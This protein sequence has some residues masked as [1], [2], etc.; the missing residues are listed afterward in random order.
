MKNK[1]KIAEIRK[2]KQTKRPARS[3]TKFTKKLTMAVIEEA[4][5]ESAAETEPE[6]GAGPNQ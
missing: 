2:N 4:A 3:V 1:N 6:E 5:Q